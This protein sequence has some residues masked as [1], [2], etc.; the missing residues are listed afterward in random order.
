MKKIIVNIFIILT[1]FSFTNLQSKEFCNPE[2]ISVEIS[3][4]SKVDDN[5]GDKGRVLVY[6]D[7]S[8]SM[9]G[10]IKLKELETYQLNLN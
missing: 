10:K 8:L 1:L 5:N 4:Q 7:Q 9:Q 3:K 6:F 2:G